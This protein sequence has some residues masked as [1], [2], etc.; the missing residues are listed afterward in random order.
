MEVDN[1]WLEL[2]EKP[3]EVAHRVRK[4]PAHI[5]LHG[6]ALCLQLFA[7]WAQSR[8]RQDRRG[9]PLLTLQT[10]HLRYQYLG[11][12]DLHAVYNV[13]NLHSVL[14]A[15]YHLSGSYCARYLGALFSAS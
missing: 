13:H 14:R 15:T 6:E 9:V 7:E 3:I 12:S 8:H 5:W 11:T 4:M 1:V 2:L 10:A